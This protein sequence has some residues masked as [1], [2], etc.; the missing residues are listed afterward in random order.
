MAVK[1]SVCII[2]KNAE[3]TLK[4]CL[5][6]LSGFSEIILIDNKSSDGT[7]KIA[8]EFNENFKNLKIFQSEFLGFGALKNLAI[9]KASNEWILSIDS[10]EVLEGETYKEILA[11]KLESNCIYAFPRRNLYR[12][13]WIKACGWSPDFVLR[14]FNKNYTKFNEN[15]VHESVEIPQD[16]KVIKLQNYLKH[17]AYNDISTLLQKCNRYSSLWAKQNENLHKKGGILKALIH[18]GFKFFRDYF[19]KKGFLYGYRGF[20]ISLVNGLTSFLKYAKLYEK[21]VKWV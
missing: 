12:G 6:S 8:K 21:G 15:L 4:E 11:L 5:E 10:D 9:S 2:V 3:K 13:V 19:L 16:S 18:G 7:L 20:V 1:I 14:L 17:Y